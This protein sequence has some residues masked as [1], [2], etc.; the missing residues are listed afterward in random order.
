M[1]FQLIIINLT[2]VYSKTISRTTIK[3]KCFILYSILDGSGGK[4]FKTWLVVWLLIEWQAKNKFTNQ[5][6]RCHPI[7]SPRKRIKQRTL[8]GIQLQR[9]VVVVY[10]LLSWSGRISYIVR[11]IV[12]H[13]SWRLQIQD[14]LSK[15]TATWSLDVTFLAKQMFEITMDLAGMTHDWL[16]LVHITFSTTTL[17]VEKLNF[18]SKILFSKKINLFTIAVVV[19]NPSFS[20]HTQNAWFVSYTR[21]NYPIL[22]VFFTFVFVRRIH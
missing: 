14:S 21:E 12:S 2:I 15:A 17:I 22:Y 1:V 16:E 7:Q 11:T 10:S 19:K 9:V 5:W 6:L 4:S 20:K 13:L 18:L 8:L 3:Y